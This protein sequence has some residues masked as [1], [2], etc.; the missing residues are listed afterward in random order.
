MARLS[1]AAAIP[2]PHAAGSRAVPPSLAV[3][4]IYEPRCA[5]AALAETLPSVAGE[6][7]L[8]D[9][10]KDSGANADRRDSWSQITAFR[11]RADVKHDLGIARVPDE[12][13]PGLV[14]LESAHPRPC[15]G[16]RFNEER[17]DCFRVDPRLTFGVGRPRGP[18]IDCR[19]A[20]RFEL[21]E[22]GR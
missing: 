20:K 15:H 17:D 18:G 13:A 22:T 9:D 8:P 16:L 1:T 6:D 10:G 21:I 19:P 4:V 12:F 3:G 11:M 2:P 7:V 14:E 5:P